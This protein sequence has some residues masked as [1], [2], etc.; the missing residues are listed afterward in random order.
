V[1]DRVHVTDAVDVSGEGACLVGVGEVPGHRGGTT[2]EEALHGREPVG[3]AG[4]DDDRVAVIEERL[5]R[6]PAQTIG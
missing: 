6:R 3:V 2:I 5:G 1:D 4:M